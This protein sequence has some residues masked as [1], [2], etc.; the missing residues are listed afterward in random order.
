LSWGNEKQAKD[1]RKSQRK[2]R[3]REE[4]RGR[5][6]KKHTATSVETLKYTMGRGL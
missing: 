5:E 3:E 4:R 6:E 1:R 2:D